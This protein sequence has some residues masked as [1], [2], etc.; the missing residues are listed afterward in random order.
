MSEHQR[1][2]TACARLVHAIHEGAILCDLPTVID[3]MADAVEAHI[4]PNEPV[5]G[6]LYQAVEEARLR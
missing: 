2:A 1:L 6:V 4:S 5:I 3:A